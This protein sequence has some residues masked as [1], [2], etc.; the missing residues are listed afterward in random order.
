MPNSTAK[1]SNIPV[2]SISARKRG[3]TRFFTGSTPSTCSASSSS[4]ILRAP[5]SAVIAVPATPAS[6]IAV[7]N[8]ANSRMRGQ[9][10]EAA[11]AVVGA[12]QREEVGGLQARRGVAERDRGDHQ[13][14][15]AQPQR[16]QELLDEL[17]AVRV[18]RTERGDDRLPGQDHHVAR[19][20]PAIP[21][22]EGRR[23]RR[24]CEP[25]LSSSSTP[26]TRGSAKVMARPVAAQTGTVAVTC[27]NGPGSR[28]R[29]AARAPG[30]GAIITPSSS[31][32]SDCR[33]R[34]RGAVVGRRGDL[35]PLEPELLERP[36][37]QQRRPRAGRRRG[38]AP[39]GTSQ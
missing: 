7:T 17:A 36:V 10:E 20:P 14:E 29:R 27:A 37:D 18:G 15:P 2:T 38:R 12:E 11:E 28:R 13:R 26:R 1:T 23:D 34:P 6:T 33:E 16:E 31:N 4:R 39:A 19:L 5:R 35:D 24:R 30:C 25:S 32:P 8:G 3:T 9:H 21:L 22:P